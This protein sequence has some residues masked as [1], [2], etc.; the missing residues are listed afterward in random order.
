MK[1]FGKKYRVLPFSWLMGGVLGCLLVLSTVQA[2]TPLDPAIEKKIDKLLEKMSVEEKA[3]QMTQIT[4]DVISKRDALGKI[5]EPQEIDTEALRVAL[6]DYHVGSMLNVGSHTF[7]KEHWQGIMPTIQ[8]M[9]AKTDQGIPVIYGVDAIHGV[10]YTSGSTLFPQEIGQAATWDPAM[11][12]KAGAVT[13]YETRASAIPWNFS[14]VLDLARQ[15]L[16]SRFFE[17]FGEDVYLASEM[18]KAIIK[19]Y[20]G[21]DISNKYKVAAC[22]KHYAGYSMPRSGKDRT[23]AW[24]PERHLREYFLPTF[25]AGV[26]AGAQTVMVNSG[27][28]NGI[29]G[30]ANYHLLTEVLHGEMGFNGFA[31][32]D[33]EDLLMLHQYHRIAATEKEAVKIAVNA[34]V[35]MSMVPLSPQYQ[36]YHRYVVE[37]VN[38]GEIS[39]ERLDEAVRRILRV[40]FNLGLFESTQA[41]LKD[42][43]EF[44]SEENAK[45]AR[46]IAQ[47]SITLLKNENNLLPLNTGKTLFVTGPTANSLT[48][49]NGAWTHTWQ[50]VEEKYNNKGKQTIKE[51]FEAQ[52]E[53]GKV[54]FHPGSG[55][56]EA[57]SP[58]TPLTP[59]KDADYIIVCLGEMPSTEKPGDVNSLDMPQAQ[60]DLVKELKAFGKPMILV[61]VENRPLIV[62][63][64]EGDFDA[65]L[66]AY[67]PGDEGGPAVADIVLGAVNPSGRL[68][69]TYPR[70]AGDIVFYDHKGTELRDSKFG[71]NAFN[72][73][74]E[75]GHGLSYT[76]Y[77]YSAL[78]LSTASLAATGN[79]EISVTVKNTGDRSG[80]EVVRLFIRDQY[81]SITPSVKRL[82]GFKKIALDAG[83]SETVTFS[84]S[85]RDLAFVDHDLKW[86]AEKGDFEVQ[87]EGLKKTFTLT[88]TKIY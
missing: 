27:E 84:I 24:I 66:N 52:N 15:P 38:E 61:L 17:T 68:P 4:L 6:E 64:I 16:W 11:V 71:L 43:P 80:H 22:L 30:H 79:L 10:T 75:F 39:Q 31:V 65:I 23:P 54:I 34:G 85:P 1:A 83:E 73:Q 82:R 25:E 29:P 62:S 47:S 59:A 60:I 58:A 78:S 41:P 3:G 21:A 40:K 45:L 14:P 37:L 46:T 77:D 8:N 56:K 86:R 51:A 7:S 87:I 9:A 67:E 5:V 28:V 49:L 33:W 36:N 26:K 70:H 13:A 32:S 19:G 69:F 57:L 12:E 81:A 72:P 55:L 42:Y 2:Q 74:W 48:C 35:D 53:K 18:G 20:Q 50:G 88:E 63:E 44:G 76:S